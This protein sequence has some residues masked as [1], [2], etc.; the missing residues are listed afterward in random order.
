MASDTSTLSSLGVG[1]M[2]DDLTVLRTTMVPTPLDLAANE[3]LGAV[4]RVEVTKAWLS[5]PRAAAP[6]SDTTENVR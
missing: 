4:E 3:G 1:H 2:R 6:S 5:E